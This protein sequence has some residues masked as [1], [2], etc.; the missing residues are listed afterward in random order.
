MTRPWHG[1]RERVFVLMREIDAEAETFDRRARALEPPP[2]SLPVGAAHLDE[3]LKCEA[4]RDFLRGMRNGDP[5]QAAAN[6]ALEDSRELVRRWNANP[7]AVSFGGKHELQRWEDTCAAMLDDRARRFAGIGP[8]F[9]TESQI[10][11]T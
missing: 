7:R 4:L 8:P 9:L 11:E 3:R 10:F 5:P 6:R 2:G 1:Y